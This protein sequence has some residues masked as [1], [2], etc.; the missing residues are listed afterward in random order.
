MTKFIVRKEK[1][2]FQ[3]WGL[4]H[5]LITLAA[6]II[7]LPFGIDNLMAAFAVG[8]FGQREYGPQ[9]LPPKTFEYLDFLAPL[10]VAILYFIVRS[11]IY[12]A[13]NS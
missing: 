5:A 3:A 6:I 7:G 10:A 2:W 8:W 1:G 9:L 12:E 13:C 11:F 4:H